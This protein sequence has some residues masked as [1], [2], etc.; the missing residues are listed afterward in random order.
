MRKVGKAREL[1]TNSVGA[2]GKQKF[3]PKVTSI[4]RTAAHAWFDNQSNSSRIHP[5]R[6]SDRAS[7]GFEGCKC[8]KISTCNAQSLGHY[9]H[10]L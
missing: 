9:F 10:F 7:L 3:Y 4:D 5:R 8:F 6:E 2:C 1:T